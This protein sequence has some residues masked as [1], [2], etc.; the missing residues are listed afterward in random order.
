MSEETEL[1]PSPTQLKD[2]MVKIMASVRERAK[3]LPCQ[4]LENR[5]PDI[6]AKIIWMLA[7]NASYKD[8]RDLTGVSNEAIR[9]IDHE[10]SQHNLAFAEQR[11]IFAN[12][13][14]MA[15]M[16]YTDLLF[17]RAEQ[18]HDDPEL[19]AQVSPEKLA[20]VVG[21]MQDKSSMLS[22]ST[23]ADLNKK[24][25]LSIDDA[26]MLIEASRQKAAEKRLNKVIEAE[27]INA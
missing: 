12:R 17:K 9:R 6:A 20:T 7:Q 11:K 19:L 18:L 8:I 14:A 22:G 3:E 27:V 16:E 4:A 23:S 5:K 26:L 25:G 21:I 13:Y 1:N 15:A 2:E 10:H 24:E